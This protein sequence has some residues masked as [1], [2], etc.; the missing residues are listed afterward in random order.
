[1]NPGDSIEAAQSAAPAAPGLVGFLQPTPTALRNGR[2]TLAIFAVF[3][4]VAVALVAFVPG[5]GDRQM[6]AIVASSC[7]ALTGDAIAYLGRPSTTRYRLGVI[8][9]T[10]AIVVG[11]YIALANPFD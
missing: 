6:L 2:R 11:F 3:V 4:A 10:I 5:F 7:F 1:M 9:T 8:L